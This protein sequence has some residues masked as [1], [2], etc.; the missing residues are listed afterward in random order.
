MINGR[1]PVRETSLYLSLLVGFVDMRSISWGIMRHSQRATC[2]YPHVYFSLLGLGPCSTSSFQIISRKLEQ[3]GST[4]ST[5]NTQLSVQLLIPAYHSLIV[6]RGREKD[7]R[8][9][10][11]WAIVYFQVRYFY[12]PGI[13]A[14]RART[15][16]LSGIEITWGR[17]LQWGS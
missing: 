10:F 5:G 16:Y 17:V 9:Q 4:T 3:W 7:K 1:N 14:L 13:M 2:I 8:S 15:H 12:W 11:K 6:Q